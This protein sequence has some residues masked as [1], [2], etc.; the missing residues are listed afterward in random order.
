ML[1]RFVD[2]YSN[3]FIFYFQYEIKTRRH[4][5]KRS[6]QELKLADFYIGNMVTIVARTFKITEFGDAYTARILSGN[7]QK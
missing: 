5:L 3:S 2:K 4:L 6:K 7:Q 1:L